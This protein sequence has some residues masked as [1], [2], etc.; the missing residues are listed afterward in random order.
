MLFRSESPHSPT[1]AE[2]LGRALD[3][4]A[5]NIG[6]SSPN[7]ERRFYDLAAP[8]LYYSHATI[9][10]SGDRT[11]DLDSF[12][13]TPNELTFTEKLDY[14]DRIFSKEPVPPGVS[15]PVLQDSFHDRNEISR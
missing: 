13:C 5:C 12:G 6:L 3:N 1:F 9:D 8:K 2:K 15:S 4:G 10:T 14:L 11:R 7:L